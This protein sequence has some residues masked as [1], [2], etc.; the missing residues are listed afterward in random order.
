MPSFAHCTLILKLSGVNS[1]EFKIDV[2]RLL[3]LGRLITEPK[4]AT[5]VKNLFRSRAES[6]FYSN[7]SSTAVLPNICKASRKYG[8]LKYFKLWFETSVSRCIHG[9]KQL[10]GERFLSIKR[11]MARLLFETPDLKQAY[12]CLNNVPSYHFW[13]LA[14]HYPDLVSRLHVQVRIME[15]FGLYGGIP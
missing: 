11:G 9:G 4:M 1:V 15:N 14:N 7:I 10:R 13:S 8:L 2:K 3:F 5:I 12:D 6:Y